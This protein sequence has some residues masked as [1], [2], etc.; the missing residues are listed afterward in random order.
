ML[1]LLLLLLLSLS[2]VKAE[3]AAVPQTVVRLP[4]ELVNGLL[5]LRNLA[6]NGQ[7]GDF[8]LDTGCQY[9]LVVES[10]AFA[11]QLRPSPTRGL[12]ATGLV[13]QHQVA[14]TSFEFGT[15]HRGPRTAI[16]TSLA[17]IRPAVGPRLLGLVGADF[18]R[19]YELVL[20]FAHRQVSCYPLG[21]EAARPFTRHDSVAFTLVNSRP[22][23]TGSVKGVPVRWLLDTGSKD[24]HLDA[25]FTQRLPSLVQS[26]GQQPEQVVGMGG[27]VAA[28]QA[29]LPSLQLGT[30]EWQ[31]V[32]IIVS[33]M[34]R[35]SSGRAL[36][37]QGILG[38]SFLSQE[39]LVSLHYGRWQLYTLTPR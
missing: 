33:A 37:Y 29:S 10:A 15:L 5:V 7:R 24:N 38:S 11:G 27:Q 23:V 4:F 35:P 31:G 21:G 39:P 19:D 16:A 12:G 26:T 2:P 18:F 9:A 34:V 25:G 30:T 13:V 28:Q 17:A 14:V 1:H 22:I 6:V 32:P 8:I 3:Q 20:D 36:A